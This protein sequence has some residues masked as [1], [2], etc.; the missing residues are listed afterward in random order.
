MYIVSGFCATLA[1]VVAVGQQGSVSSSFGEGVEFRAIAASV[2]GGTSL[3]GGIG[4]VFPGAIVG[5]LLIQMLQN[6]MIYQ[7]VDIYLQDI[8][9]GGIILFAVF[10]DAQPTALVKKL[11]RRNIR[12]ERTTSYAPDEKKA[13]STI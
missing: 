13:R 3:F 5:T 8:V 12:M 10:I 4:N 11:E 7:Q 1:M 9:I 6:G 2:L